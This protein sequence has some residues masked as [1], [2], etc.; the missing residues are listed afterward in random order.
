MGTGSQEE[1]KKQPKDKILYSLHIL[2]GHSICCVVGMSCLLSDK[3]DKL[4][5]ILCVLVPLWL[6]EQLL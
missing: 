4:I 6:P 1:Y 2:W 3:V 5:C